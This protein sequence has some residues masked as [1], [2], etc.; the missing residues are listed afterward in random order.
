MTLMSAANGLFIFT[1]LL[2]LEPPLR[3]SNMSTFNATRCENTA[4]PLRFGREQ[5]DADQVLCR[6]TGIE[7]LQAH[8]LKILSDPIAD[9]G[10][11]N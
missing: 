1:L 7:L 2:R 5:P 6:R 4:A 8:H 9:C 3:F 11:M 10:M